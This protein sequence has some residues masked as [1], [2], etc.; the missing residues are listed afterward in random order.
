LYGGC[1]W[2]LGLAR[3]EVVRARWWGGGRGERGGHV[4]ARAPLLVLPW[5]IPAVQVIVSETRFSICVAWFVEGS[6]SI[7]LQGGA[8]KVKG[9]RDGTLSTCFLC[10][11]SVCF[12][13]IQTCRWGENSYSHVS[14]QMEMIRS[15]GTSAFLWYVTFKSC[16][17]GWLSK[18]QNGQWETSSSAWTHDILK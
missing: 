18:I 10:L 12:V 14:P 1:A 4:H 5:R 17:L 15:Q 2:G 6:W 3:Y 8:R 9:A 7:Q 16:K 11:E 13:G